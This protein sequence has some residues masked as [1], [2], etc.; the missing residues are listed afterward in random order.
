[1]GKYKN[2]ILQLQ[3][4]DVP[5]DSN[6]LYAK[7]RNKIKA[8]QQNRIKITAL[9]LFMGVLLFSGVS[10]NFLLFR[11]AGSLNISDYVMQSEKVNG[12]TVM[13]Y[14]FKD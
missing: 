9:T 11:D 1:M 3:E 10:S 14:V 7:I 8:S 2:Y 4:A 12:N 13:S 5:F 6:A